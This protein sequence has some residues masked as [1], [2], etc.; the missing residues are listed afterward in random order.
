MA[1]SLLRATIRP[2]PTSDMGRHDFCY[3][4][5]PHAADAV[6]AGINNLAFE[7]NIPLGKADVDVSEICSGKLWLQAVKL[8]ENGRQ[9]VVRLCEQNGARGEINLGRK[10]KILNMLEDEI[11]ETEI[12]EYK[13]FEIITLGFEL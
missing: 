7:Y 4:I 3:M 13:P 11:G 1:L 10:A 5:Y 2:D 12:L 8:S 9:I 6:T